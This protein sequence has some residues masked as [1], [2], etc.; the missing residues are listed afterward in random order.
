VSEVETVERAPDTEPAPRFAYA[1][2]PAQ[3]ADAVYVMH[4]W[5]RSYE[6]SAVARDMGRSYYLSH[7]RTIRRIL[8]RADVLV[9]CLEDD[10]E[11]IVGYAVTGP[12]TVFY[13]YVKKDFR[14]LGIA[15]AL[16]APYL[17]LA[18][19]YTHKSARALPVPAS[20][21]YVP[22]AN[23]HEDITP[24]EALAAKERAT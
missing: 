9:A 20:W 22:G 11:T 24:G 4:S 3:P 6:S 13:V 2:R 17:E 23:H 7:E 12:E 5:L 10:P 16:L 8:E 1:L 15:R 18:T 19:I 21:V 14:R